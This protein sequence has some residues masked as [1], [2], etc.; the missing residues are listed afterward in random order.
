MH[1][2][3]ILA[4]IGQR[5][6]VRAIGFP[7]HLNVNQSRIEQSEG[8]VPANALQG[9]GDY[10]IALVIFAGIA[11]FFVLR[12]RSVLGKRVGFE[13][14][15]MPPGQ[16][17][18]G[19][20]PVIEGQALPVQNGHPV[21]DPQS[22]LG[23]RLMQIVNR[24]RHFDPPKFLASAETT[25][26]AVV[27]AFAAGNRAVLKNFL[28]ES[29]YQTFES[30]IAA[31]EAANERHQTDIKAILSATIEDA[32]LVGDQAA[33]IVRFSS[34]Q[35]NVTLDSGGNALAGTDMVA[36]IVDLWTF[37]RNLK[38]NDLTWRLAAARSG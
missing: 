21:P 24:D 28:S 17:P 14:P 30:A 36:E 20:G 5:L 9:L 22:S 10:P 23:Q 27:T 3:R 6:N 13:K 34:D 33:I 11:I 37:E 2:C 4:M 26:R 35:I 8:A 16:P 29:V 1:V 32:Q 12:L 7:Y 19:R 31:R 18:F 25:F 38:S 15:P